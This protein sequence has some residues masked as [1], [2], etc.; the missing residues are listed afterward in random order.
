M[1][2]LLFIIF[3]LMTSIQAFSQ[4][5]KKVDQENG[6]GVFKLG[7]HFM[8]YRPRLSYVGEI[9][10]E[11]VYNYKLDQEL[12]IGDLAMKTVFLSFDENEH[13]SKIDLFKA[14]SSTIPL[15][16]S[17][18]D[19]LNLVKFYTEWYSTKSMNQDHKNTNDT[20]LDLIWYGDTVMIELFYTVYKDPSKNTEI[21]MTIAPKNF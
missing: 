19:F 12:K 7:N 2:K 1:R 11:K 6:I 5:S 14:Y 8:D 9:M 4:Y 13:L 10:G 18:S 3:G 21:S 16:L 20:T 15:E 17:G